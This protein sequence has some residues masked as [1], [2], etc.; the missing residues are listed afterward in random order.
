VTNFV[1]PSGVIKQ[2]LS[3]SYSSVINCFENVP[4]NSLSNKTAYF[5]R[6]RFSS[7]FLDGSRF[8]SNL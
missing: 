7:V 1:N 5:M 8:G 3:N 2:V 6:S 4:R